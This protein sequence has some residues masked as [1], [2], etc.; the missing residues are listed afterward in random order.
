ME[1]TV[2]QVTT[3]SRAEELEER[4]SRGA[5][6]LFDMELRGETAGNYESWLQRWQ[7]LLIEYESLDAA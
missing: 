5:E 6:L 4:L 1:G 7:E 2:R 3:V